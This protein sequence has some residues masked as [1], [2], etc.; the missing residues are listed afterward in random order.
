MTSLTKMGSCAEFIAVEQEYVAFKPANLEFDQASSAPLVGLTS[1]QA[2]VQHSQL[3]QGERVLVIDG[4]SATGIYGIQLA[5]ALGCYVTATTSSRS[6]EFFKPLGANEIVDY[7]TTKWVGVLEPHSVG[8]LEPHSVGVVYDCGMKPNSSNS[9]A[10]TVL[11]DIGRFVTLMP[12]A[13]PI[14]PKFGTKLIGT[15]LAYPNAIQMCELTKLIESGKIVTPID[16]VFAFEDAINVIAKLA[17]RR[18]RGKF[19]ISIAKE[20]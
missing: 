15:I 1:Y 12:I 20:K 9:D 10:Q 5:K 7:T 13:E 6:T 17:T 18:T 3:Q 2:L 16:S 14:E 4:S 19:V 11:K 8:V